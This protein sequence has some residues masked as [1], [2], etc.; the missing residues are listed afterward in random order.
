MWP[1]KKKRKP[2]GTLTCNGATFEGVDCGMTITGH[3][4]TPHATCDACNKVGH[5]AGMVA[6]AM[7]RRH[8]ANGYEK[9]PVTPED[10]DYSYHT[11]EAVVHPHCIPG[12]VYDR[13][14]P[15]N[16][17]RAKQEKGKP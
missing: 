6:V 4:Q 14:K 2:S 9:Q 11:W 15:D 13:R 16:D 1:F 12:S 10:M 5:T 17:R 3:E 8:A 7:R